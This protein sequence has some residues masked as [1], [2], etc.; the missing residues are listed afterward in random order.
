MGG[1]NS[2]LQTIEAQVNARSPHTWQEQQHWALIE[3]RPF[4]LELRVPQDRCF[5]H[6]L[7]PPS[8][9]QHW[10][11]T[12]WSTLRLGGFVVLRAAAQQGTSPS[13]PNPE[14]SRVWVP[15]RRGIWRAGNYGEP[16]TFCAEQGLPAPASPPRRTQPG[17]RAGISQDKN[18][19][20]LTASS[21]AKAGIH[22]LISHRHKGRV[23]APVW[24]CQS[25][26]TQPQTNYQ[27]K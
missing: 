2:K 4:S 16:Q 10:N 23:W 27:L 3:T 24:K 13:W 11:S 9:I 14:Q 25:G 7:T 15:G 6:L 17:T 5:G 8:P 1:W 26:V 19:S 22:D 21:L 18:D 12:V 20:L